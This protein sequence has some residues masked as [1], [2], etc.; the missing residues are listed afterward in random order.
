MTLPTPLA[1]R[2]SSAKSWTAAG[3]VAIGVAGVVAFDPVHR[4]VPLCPFHAVTGW[5]CPF[6]GSLRAVD[7]LAHLQVTAALQDNLLLVAAVP[8]VVW[9]WLEAVAHSK[10]G[11]PQRSVP[12]G[13]LVAL[14]TLGVVFTVVRNLPTM[15]GLR[16]A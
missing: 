5:W 10:A 11:R 12:V 7:S 4:H 6:C 16:P 14:I 8:L 9:W 2:R 13:A 3:A 15:S 1:T